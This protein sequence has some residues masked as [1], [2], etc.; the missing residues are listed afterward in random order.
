MFQTTFAGTLLAVSLF[1]WG[2][3]GGG[4]WFPPAPP[5]TPPPQKKRR[6]KKR[7]SWQCSS[8]GRLK[9][10]DTWVKNRVMKFKAS[11]IQSIRSGVCVGGG[12]GGEWRGDRETVFF[13]FNCT[14][15]ASQRG[16]PAVL[17][18]GSSIRHSLRFAGSDR[19]NVSM[20]LDSRKTIP[21]APAPP[22]NGNGFYFFYKKKEGENKGAEE[23][24]QSAAGR[25][26]LILSSAL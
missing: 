25:I 1:F 8:Q 2:G 26:C 18:S 21:R 14:C 22:G 4:L 16:A 9:H 17:L 11:H 23:E 5:P 15:A 13:F 7:H 6:R 20:R 3:G 19:E 24:K 12:R 10:H